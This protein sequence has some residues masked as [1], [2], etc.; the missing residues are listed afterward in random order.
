MRRLFI[1]AIFVIFV[2]KANSQELSLPKTLTIEHAPGR[3]VTVTASGANRVAWSLVKPDGLVIEG[4]KGDTTLTLG[5]PG[6]GTKFFVIA[7]AADQAGNV[8]I[9]QCKVE[10][11]GG[12]DQKS[13][14]VDRSQQTPKTGSVRHATLL[15]SRTDTVASLTE[16]LRAELTKRGIALHVLAVAQADPEF[17]TLHDQAK[18]CVVLQAEDGSVIPEGQVFT[19]R[20]RGG[21]EDVRG[22]LANIDGANQ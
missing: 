14:E 12:S 7:A 22:L 21:E 19:L 5:M 18:D 6:P 1:A 20:L 2:G 4:I 15:V 16:P 10:I 13:T 17:K 8:T 11:T 3:L 9:A